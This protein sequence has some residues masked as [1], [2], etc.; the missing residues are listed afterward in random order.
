MDPTFRLGRFYV[1]PLVYENLTLIK[2]RDGKHPYFVGPTFVHQTRVTEDYRYFIS[3]LKIINPTLKLI[4]AVGIDDEL[5]LS[6]AVLAELPDAIRLKCKIHKRE[7]IKRKLRA[8]KISTAYENE[9]LKDIFGEVTGGTLFRGLYHAKNPDA[10]DQKLANLQEKWEQLAPGFFHW[11]KKEEAETFKTSMIESVRSAA[12]VETDFTMNP[13][14]S[15]NE[16]MKSWVDREKSTMTVFNEKFENLRVAQESEAE[17]AIYRCGEYELA[18][19][20][21]NLQVEPHKWKQL[22]PQN[23]QKHIAKLWSTGIED[24]QNFENLV[25]KVLGETPPEKTCQEIE[26]FDFPSSSTSESGSCAALLHEENRLSQE[27]CGTEFQDLIA[28]SV[29][30]TSLNLPSIP[31]MALKAIWQKA[32]ELMETPGMIEKCPGNPKARMVASRRGDRPHQVKELAGGKVTCDCSNYSS[33]QICAYSVAAAEQLGCLEKFIQWRERCNSKTPNFTKLVMS[34]APKG[35]GEK[36]G[37]TNAK[38]RGRTARRTTVYD[39]D[40]ERPSQLSTA[41]G[42]VSLTPTRMFTEIH[43]NENPFVLTLFLEDTEYK[44]KAKV[45]ENKGRR[46]QCETCHNEFPSTCIPPYDLALPHY[47]RWRYPDPDNHQGPWKV[48]HKETAKV[49]RV[50]PENCIKPRL[51]HF[52]D[53]KVLISEDMMAKLRT[54]HQNFL[55]M[56][57]R[58]SLLD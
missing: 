54:V 11:F 15:L 57:L 14:E 24:A 22:S 46:M 42:S 9:I 33:I 44:K 7:N 26:V 52:S 3:Q 34:D 13:S 4:Q 58:I 40:E 23:R 2:R 49:Y 27:S 35:A 50:N 32:G 38:R 37:R 21:R 55:R 53:D 41:S 17:K 28:I 20:F 48:S 31:S 12:Q 30:V 29:P 47:E 1:T 10:F 36:N 18:E 39:R 16:E 6:N 5:A 51:P 43:Q 25:D 56:H 8:M 45:A 19:N